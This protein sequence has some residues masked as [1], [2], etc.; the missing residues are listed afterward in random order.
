MSLVEGYEMKINPVNNA[1][2]LLNR[3]REKQEHGGQSQRDPQNQQQEQ[4]KQQEPLPEAVQQAVEAFQTDSQTQ[5]NG[6][7][8]TMEGSGPGLR[9]VLKDGSGGVVRQFT[10]E[11]FIKLREAAGQD[12]RARG[13]IL[14][15]KL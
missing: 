8:A 11:E 6:L 9:V 13:K 14:D 12:T 2:S 4:P 15:Q 10:G 7:S 1:L 3:V 5:S